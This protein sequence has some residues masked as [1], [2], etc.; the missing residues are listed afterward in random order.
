MNFIRQ[1]ALAAL[2]LATLGS[3]QAL[4]TSHQ[5]SYDSN[6]AP[7]A[8]TN[9]SIETWLPQFNS[10][11]GTLDSVTVSMVSHL[12]GSAKAESKNAVARDVTLNLQATFKLMDLTSG[13]TWL[14][15]TELVSNSFVASAYDG[16]RDFGGNSGRSYLDLMA[17]SGTSLTFTDSVMLARFIGTG[18]VGTLLSAKG[19]SRYLSS[20]SIDA[21]FRNKASGYASVSYAYHTTAVPEPGT[22][23]L[24][25]AGLGMVLMLASRRRAD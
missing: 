10:Q 25:A 19:E 13:A 15:K 14:Q 7:L 17:D 23:A 6:A 21:Q 9:W 20:S 18:T 3:A 24:M 8:S 2:L 4:T 5:I 11:L 1:T 22:W 16:T 12:E